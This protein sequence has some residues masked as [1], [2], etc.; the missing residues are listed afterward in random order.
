MT[1]I[2]REKIT[3]ARMIALYCRKN[4]GNTELCPA[5]RELL[6]YAHQRLDRCPFGN[7][8]PACKKCTVHCYKPDMR[9]R[10]REV[11]RFAG[12]RLIFYHPVGALAHIRI[13]I[14]PHCR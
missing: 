3:V 12:P 14:K 1:R 10:M 9:Q 11:M 7:D 6:A 2:E 4:E 5:C 8:K 13:R